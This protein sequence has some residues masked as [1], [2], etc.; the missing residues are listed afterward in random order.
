MVLQPAHIS[1]ALC[2][3]EASVYGASVH[4]IAQASL[5]HGFTPTLI[6]DGAHLAP[7]GEAAL[8]PFR[9]NRW[10]RTVT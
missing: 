10:A 8:Y 7:A 1:E 2:I 9:M 6:L 5:R 4:V 3:T